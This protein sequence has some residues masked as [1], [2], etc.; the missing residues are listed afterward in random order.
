MHYVRQEACQVAPRFAALIYLHSSDER[1][2]MLADA[3][4]QAARVA[5]RETGT[6]GTEWHEAQGQVP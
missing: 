3:V 4:G 6:S 5:L 1:Q 2:R